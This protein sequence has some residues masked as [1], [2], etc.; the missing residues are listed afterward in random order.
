MNSSEKIFMLVVEEMSF[1]K[2]AK[3][4]LALSQQMVDF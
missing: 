3:K 2:A 1:T 4:T